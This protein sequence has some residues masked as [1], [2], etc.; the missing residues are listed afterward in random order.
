MGLA[1]D[2]F[3]DVFSFLKN[4]PKV[5]LP[6]FILSILY[7]LFSSVLASSV[8]TLATSIDFVSISIVV[9]LSVIMFFVSLI[10]SGAYQIMVYQAVKKGKVNI[11]EAIQ[12][13]LRIFFKIFLTV[14]LTS[15]IVAVPGILTFVPTL[16]LL[17][18]FLH[19][20]IVFVVV[21]LGIIVYVS[22][23]LSLTFPI[24]IIE[25]KSPTESIKLSWRMTKDN[26]VSIL[27][28]TFLLSLIIG[29]IS[30]PFNL[31]KAFFEFFQMPQFTSIFDI[32]VSTISGAILGPAMAIYYLNLKKSK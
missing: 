28:L 14:L 22:L 31:L 7:S 12:K 26:L 5:V 11:K 15:L 1:L 18:N 8:T 16:L 9:A 29:V 4:Y 23:R 24:L 27:A 21:I 6:A 20:L 2:S 32:L 19:I 3:E 30:F 17:K 10:F 25:N 13:S